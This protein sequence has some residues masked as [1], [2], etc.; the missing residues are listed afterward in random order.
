LA[1]RLAS[2]DNALRQRRILEHDRRILEWVTGR[3]GLLA[4]P[5][6]GLPADEA[7][8]WLAALRDAFGARWRAIRQSLCRERRLHVLARSEGER[9]P[10]AAVAAL[11]GSFDEES[12]FDWQREVETKQPQGRSRRGSA[13]RP[14]AG[15][16]RPSRA[17]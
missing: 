3:A 1:Q 8:R 6:A 11:L 4:A 10:L 5:E 13:P 7:N 12:G 9:P 14:G 17:E 15:V 16:S 2:C